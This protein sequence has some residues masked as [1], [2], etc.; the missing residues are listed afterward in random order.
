M[1]YVSD[2]KN[3]Q[4]LLTSEGA[5]ILFYFFIT[6]FNLKKFLEKFKASWHFWP[7]IKIGPVLEKTMPVVKN[8]SAANFSFQM[9]ICWYFWENKVQQKQQVINCCFFTDSVIKFM[10]LLITPRMLKS[11]QNLTFVDR[12]SSD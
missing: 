5:Q 8:H 7:F 4:T 10:I 9:D 2:V 12:W 1:L 6:W 3:T 11:F